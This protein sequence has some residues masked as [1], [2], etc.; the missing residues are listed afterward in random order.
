MHSFRARLFALWGLSLVAC[1]AVG[2]LFVQLYQQSTEAQVGRAEAVVARACDLIRNRFDFYARAWHGPVPSFADPTLRQELGA[3]VAVALGRQDGIEGGIWQT[4][5]GSLAYAFPTYQ[6]TGPKT[7]FPVAE[8]DRVAAIN[9]QALRDE[10]PA[11]ARAATRAQTLL[12]HACP[13][14]G[15][16]AG[17]SAWTMTRVQSALGYGPLQLGLGVLF[18]LMMG[19]TA[20]LTRML[21]VWARQLRSIERT[22]RQADASGLPEIRATGERELDR[23]VDALNDARRRLGDARRDSERFAARAANAER[24]AALGRVAAGVA[25]EIRNPL[26]VL[27]LQGENALAGDEAR[28]RTAIVDM[29]AQVGRL[30]TLVTELLAMTQRR[31]PNPTKIDLVPFLQ[32]RLDAHRAAADA[33]RITLACESG[34]TTATLDVALVERI[35][36]NLLTNAVRHAPDGG[37][38][39]LTAQH[40]DGSLAIEVADSGAGV[41]PT[42]RERLFEPFVTGRA[43]GTGLGLAIARELADAHGGRLVLRENRA[44]ADAE[45]TIFS[46]EL[47]QDS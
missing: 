47:P 31:T 21:V 40:R 34:V 45:A 1:V 5:A 24:L 27:R 4:E 26:A 30:D 19:I 3:V 43:D 32:R 41:S 15:P 42:M 9:Q 14:P 16:I 2:I 39:R 35:L 17:L 33:R 37:L 12:L 28:R 22:L 8:R 44:E 46:L 29:L 7:D 36:D 38:V 25:H 13:L 23:I 11:G 18:A 20:L 10:Q 6:G